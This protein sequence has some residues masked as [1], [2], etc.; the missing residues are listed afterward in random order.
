MEDGKL[1]D[2][3]CVSILESFFVGSCGVDAILPVR[4]AGPRTDGK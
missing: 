1:F 4:F 2:A 3:N